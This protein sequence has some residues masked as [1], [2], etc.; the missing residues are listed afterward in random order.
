MLAFWVTVGLKAGLLTSLFIIVVPMMVANAVVLSYVIT[1]HF[2]CKLSESSDVL[3]TTMSVR[4]WKA[5][6]LI[7]FHFSHHIEHH[8]FPGMASCYYPLVRKRLEAVAGTSYL[9]PYHITALAMVLRTP[10]IYQSNDTLWKPD[11]G[12]TTAIQVVQKMLTTNEPTVDCSVSPAD[13]ER[14]R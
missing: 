4:T 14:P 10:R 8:L 9:A 2:L 11:S 7:H 6:D 12:Q 1:N 13:G 5:L 3:E